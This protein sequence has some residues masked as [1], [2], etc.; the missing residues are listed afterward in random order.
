LEVIREGSDEKA[1]K[2]RVETRVKTPGKILEVLQARPDATLSEVAET[3]GKSKSAVERAA[4]KLTAAGRLRRTGPKKGG[5][6]EV[7]E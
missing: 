1:G 4:K 3:I 7:V 6:W 2:T 5:C